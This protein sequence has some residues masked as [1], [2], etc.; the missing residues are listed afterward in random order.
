MYIVKY[1]IKQHINI[2]AQHI[3]RMFDED[4]FNII[5][6]QGNGLCLVQFFF[7]SFRQ[8]FTFVYKLMV[9]WCICVQCIVYNMIIFIMCIYVQNK[10][11]M[12]WSY[13]LFN[14]IV[15]VFH[16]FHCDESN[17]NLYHFT[18]NHFFFLF[19]FFCFHSFF[20]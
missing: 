13:F 8:H 6:I 20:C 5:S 7:S 1:Y 2:S 12:K 15:C 17:L 19:P 10:L 4:A 14:M 3:L 18:E 9:A 16:G 11:T